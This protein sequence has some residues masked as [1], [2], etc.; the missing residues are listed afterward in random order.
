MKLILGGRFPAKGLPMFQIEH[1]PLQAPLQQ[2]FLWRGLGQ[3]QSL[4]FLTVEKNLPHRRVFRREDSSVTKI[5]P[6]ERVFRAEPERNAPRAWIKPES[7]PYT[8]HTENASIHP[9]MWHAKR[10]TWKHCF[11]VVRET[12]HLGIKQASNNHTANRTI[13][14]VKIKKCGTRFKQKK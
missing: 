2:A 8:T 4:C 13:Q 5:C 1:A 12:P 11:G 6:Y 7:R 14:K 3:Y 10:A 9:W